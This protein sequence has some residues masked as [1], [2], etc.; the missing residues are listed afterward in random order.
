M[1]RLAA[2]PYVSEPFGHNTECRVQ[3]GRLIHN[4]NDGLRP[5]EC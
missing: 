4:N 3:V 2:L 1:M 5:F